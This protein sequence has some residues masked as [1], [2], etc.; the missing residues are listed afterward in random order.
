MPGS[1]RAEQPQLHLRH[2]RAHALERGQ[3]VLRRLP[4]GRVGHHRHDRPAL[5][6]RGPGAEGR[7]L[8]AGPDQLGL[9]AMAA[10]AGEQ[11]A[12]HRQHARAPLEHRGHAG[13]I[14]S[15]VSLEEEQLRTLVRRQREHALRVWLG[16]ASDHDLGV[17]QLLRAESRR[18]QH[19]DPRDR[20]CWPLADREVDRRR[21]RELP[22]E[23]LDHVD[24]T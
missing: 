4:V 6:D 23:R 19:R 8:E 3:P 20:A 1:T 10:G 22:R 2:R 17:G 15:P 14:G 12:R 24:P 21:A 18:G 16:E 7:A 11:E 9:A 5:A 13:V